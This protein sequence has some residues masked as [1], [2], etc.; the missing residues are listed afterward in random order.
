MV[1]RRSLVEQVGRFRLGY[2]GWPD[3]DLALRIISV[4][5]RVGH[6][7]GAVPLASDSGSAAAEPVAK[8]WA[9]AAAKRALVAH[10]ERTQLDA[11]V[12]DGAAV[13]LFR[14]R[15]RVH[16]APLV[17]LVITTDDR[18]R[19]VQGRLRA[20][21]PDC[22]DGIVRRTTYANYELLIIDNGQISDATRD[23]LAKV[24]HRR[25]SYRIEGDFNFAHKLNF[26]V[27][28]ARGEHLVVL[29]DDVEVISSEWLSAMLDLAD[30]GVGAVG[31]K[32][33]YPDGRLQHIGIVM[34][35]CGLAAHAFHQAPG[36][37]GGA[38]GSATGPRNYSAVTGAC[39][40]TRRSVFD[41]VGGFNERLAIDFND[42]DYCLRVRRA[43][44]RIVLAP[45]AELYRRRVEQPGA[46][47]VAPEEAEYHARRLARR[48]RR[49]PVLQPQ[50]DSRFS[51]L[52]SSELGRF[53]FSV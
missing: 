53:P 5:S 30:P 28:H 24:P 41:Q 36:H 44:Y 10:V 29:N 22:V 38:A 37:S 46:A 31:A 2:K 43:G 25:V 19:D 26:S 27:T 7:Q 33:Y 48:A 52:P 4:S 17:T 32:L 34:G 39:M 42:V 8:P 6:I 49:Q 45:Y 18:S 14:V 23:M 50:P 16:G 13:G 20:L 15:R 47:S 21:L 51:G 9:L 1:L 11:N 12:L 35:V 40:M 3:Y